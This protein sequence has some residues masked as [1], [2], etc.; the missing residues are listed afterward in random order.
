MV[1]RLRQA[2]PKL[3]F[4]LEMITRDPL[5]IPCLTKKYF[6]T[7]PALSAGELAAALSRVRRQTS[8]KAL[9][10]T[11]GLSTARQLQLEDE[12]VRKSFA[13]A[14]RELDFNSV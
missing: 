11:S 13:Y 12:Q 6:A 3:Q 4:S 9:P 14:R 1:T 7:M 10:R 5:K 2:N 8:K